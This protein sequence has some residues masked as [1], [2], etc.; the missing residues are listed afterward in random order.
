MSDDYIALDQPVSVF[1]SKRN[2]FLSGLA[3]LLIVCIYEATNIAHRATSPPVAPLICDF[4]N[5]SEELPVHKVHNL[6][7]DSALRN[8]T[9][10]KLQNAV[11]IPT[12]IFDTA[13]NPEV[14]ANDKCWEPFKKLHKQLAKDFPAVWSKLEVEIVNH[15]GLIITWKGSNPKLKPIM[16]AAHQDVVPVERKT[17]DKWQH[18]P[19][20]GDLT[21]DAEWGTLMW[22][23]GSFDDKNQL[24]G[25]LQAVEYLLTKEK[26]FTPERG[27][28]IASGFDEEISGHFGAQYIASVL[29]ERYGHHGLLSIIDEGVV[30]VKEIDGVLIAAP[31]T[32]EKGRFDMW[33]HLNTPGGH[34]S[35]PPDHT[36]IGIA[37]EVISE[38]ES[39]KFPAAFTERNP[40]SHYYR[41]IAKHSDTMS[42]SIKKDFATAMINSEANS[43]VLKYLFETG[44]R[45]TEYL[46]R[47]THAFDIIHGGIKANALPETVS[48]FV[49]SRISV[50]S[51]SAEVIDSFLTKIL[52]VAHKY[53]LGLTA[54]G[55]E[56]LP[57]TPNGNFKLEYKLG[58]EPAPVSPPNEVWG[59]FAGSIK[60]F[61]EDVI[62]PQKFNES[63][64]L[65]VA[66][67]I[68]T[69]NTDT[70]H[71]WN[72][73]E[74]I[75]RYQPGFAMEDTLSTIHS[76]DEHINFETVMHVV[77][78][79]YGYIHAANLADL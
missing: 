13:V 28:I 25:V 4:V 5:K 32:G 11:R 29:E 8:Q 57:A 39:E 3:A 55:E 20:S 26:D 22:G 33:I 31:G 47:S 23:R 73:T 67:S 27:I 30:G 38:I 74:N 64:E 62:F 44:G 65:I 15:Y 18:E 34:S 43:R 51:G 48:F 78:F 6:L 9:I 59:L 66:P 14:D 63:R 58:P 2:W 70:V 45:K 54:D 61:Y 46:F 72:L 40:V 75:Y 16:F 52:K 42:P 79:T 49:D 17:W 24:I 10:A 7:A 53:N 19:F 76:V 68:M 71:Y 12:E 60:T 69:A 36:S 41:C 56:I 50:E 21:E 37:A 35:V 77:A 1:R